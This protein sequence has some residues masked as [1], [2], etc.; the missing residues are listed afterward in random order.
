MIRGIRVAV[1][2]QDN[3]RWGIVQKQTGA[4]RLSLGGALACN[5]HGRGLA[6]KPIVDQV[7]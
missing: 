1:M 5:A 3:Q 6:L 4:D 2:I 7:E